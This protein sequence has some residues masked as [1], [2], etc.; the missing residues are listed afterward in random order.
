MEGQSSRFRLAATRTCL[1]AD[2][3]YMVP[4]VKAC[5]PPLSVRSC[6]R[7][8]FS[9]TTYG[10]RYSRVSSLSASGSPMKR[11]VL[12]SMCERAAHAVGRLVEIH[13]DALE[14]PLDRLERLGNLRIAHAIGL[15]A[16]GYL[17]AQAVGDVGQVAER[18]GVMA[19][20]DRGIDR[21]GRR[22]CGRRR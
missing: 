3:E 2:H 6:P 11:S 14:I 8:T 13:A 18:G 21:L 10:G 7:Y 15:L 9:G 12:G 16:E 1:P 20:E 4:G 22:G 19:V 5:H 17:L